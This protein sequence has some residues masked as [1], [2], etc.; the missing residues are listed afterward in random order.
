MVP[1]FGI[2]T[3]ETATEVTV[4]ADLAANHRGALERIETKSP[5][6]YRHHAMS[7]RAAGGFCRDN[8]P[9]PATLQA[10]PRQNPT[11]LQMLADVSRT[12]AG[13]TQC[14]NSANGGPI[15]RLEAA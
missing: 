10:V 7:R 2:L 1:V 12:A 15:A 11:R 5:F 9:D 3:D 6:A 14:E 13:G 4:I 8:G